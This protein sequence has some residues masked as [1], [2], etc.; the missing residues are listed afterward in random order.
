MLICTRRPPRS[1]QE[2]C[3]PQRSPS[4]A[5]LRR[6]L[7]FRSLSNPLFLIRSLILLRGAFCRTARLVGVEVTCRAR[8]MAEW[9]MGGI[10]AMSFFASVSMVAAPTRC[11]GVQSGCAPIVRDGGSRSLVAERHWNY[12]HSR[13][14]FGSGWG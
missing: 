12:Y 4:L 7:F 13:G 10:L 14:R 6:G 1:A 11:G 9:A 8:K 3:A 2:R 5:P